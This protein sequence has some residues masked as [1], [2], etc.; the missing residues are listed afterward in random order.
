MLGQYDFRIE[1][2]QGK[3]HQNADALSRNPLLVPVTDQVIETNAVDS[4]KQAWLQGCTAADMQSKQEA[5]PNL[6]Q[7][8]LWKR[9]P[10][11]QP[12]QQDLQGASKATK[13]LWTQWNRLQLENIVL[14][15]KWETEDG[16]DTRWQLVPVS[17]VP[18]VLSAL[19][20][21]PSAG[22]L[23]V[24][25]TV[26]RVRE[27]FYWY[28]L[29]SDVEDWCRQCEKCTKRKSPQTNARA[30]LV[31]SCPGYPF[32]RIAIDIMGPLQVTQS[33]SRYILV[34]GDYFT[35]WKKAHLDPEPGGQNRRRETRVSHCQV[36]STG[37]NPFLPGSQ[38]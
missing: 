11:A 6:K 2:R 27:R 31:S 7:M 34:V 37:A 35:K 5:D 4:G 1:H 36:R 24:A 8:L 25:K 23:V 21:A 3:K 14:Y 32:E 38:F 29:Q 33:G 10:A 17:D 18:D 30:P 9:D 26:E 15:R 16:H 20:D 22:H 28:G 19:R 13:S 12:T